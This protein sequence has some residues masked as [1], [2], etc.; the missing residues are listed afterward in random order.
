MDNELKDWLQGWFERFMGRF[1]RMDGNLHDLSGRYNFLNGERLLDN[2]DICQ[3]LH[4][5]KR[6]LQRYR[7]SG[8]LPFQT[9]YHKT[10]YRESDVDAFIQTH[11]AKGESEESEDI[12]DEDS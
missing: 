7:S 11:F 12:N 1:D 8:E 4:V 9:I 10:Y 3:L 2:Q 5:S 6:T